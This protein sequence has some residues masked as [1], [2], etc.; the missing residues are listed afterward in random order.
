MFIPKAA[1]WIVAQGHMRYQWLFSQ[2]EIS[3]LGFLKRISEQMVRIVSNFIE[4]SQNFAYFSKKAAKS[5]E[6]RQRK[7]TNYV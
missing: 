7:G 4:A 6:N 5:R 1:F 3:L 2:L